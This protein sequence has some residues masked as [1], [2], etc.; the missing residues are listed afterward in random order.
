M[1][2]VKLHVIHAKLYYSYQQ[3]YF[4]Y[5]DN[6]TI[7]LFITCVEKLFITTDKIIWKSHFQCIIFA[8]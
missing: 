7:I 6:K 2:F 1:N 8:S 5:T 3:L 4:L